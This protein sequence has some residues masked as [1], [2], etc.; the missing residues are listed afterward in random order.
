MFLKPSH[1]LQG[2]V[3]KPADVIRNCRHMIRMLKLSAGLSKPD[4]YLAGLQIG[5]ARAVWAE[6]KDG[7]PLTCM[8]CKHAIARFTFSTG[9]TA[10]TCSAYGLDRELTSQ[11]A[12]EWVEKLQHL[13]ENTANTGDLQRTQ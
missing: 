3:A 2:M 13:Y 12:I 4:K 6:A 5:P 9:W 8:Y 7:H 10:E 1:F 11:H